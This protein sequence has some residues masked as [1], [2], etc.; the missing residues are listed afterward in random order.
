M[1]SILCV[2]RKSRL[3]DK[4][5]FIIFLFLLQDQITLD[6]STVFSVVDFH[7]FVGVLYGVMGSDFAFS[8][9]LIAVVFENVAIIVLGSA[10]FK[11]LTD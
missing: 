8:H 4:V 3:V 11:S 2:L 7:H 6:F 5:V 10:F 1:N 9:V